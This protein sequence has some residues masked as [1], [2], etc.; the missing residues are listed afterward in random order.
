VASGRTFEWHSADG[1]VIKLQDYWSGYQVLEG[2]TGLGKP[3]YQ[4]DNEENANT[5]GVTPRGSR[6]VI[7]QVFLPMHIWGASRDQLLTRCDDLAE[8]IN[9]KNG[10]GYLYIFDGSRQYRLLCM[11]NSGMEGDESQSMAGQSGGEFWQK[12]GPTFNSIDPYF[13]DPLLLSQDWGYGGAVPFFPIPPIRLNPNQVLSDVSQPTRNNWVANPSAETNVSN[14]SNSAL[15]STPSIITRDVVV[16]KKGDWAFRLEASAAS[17]G[18]FSFPDYIG[19][20]LVVNQTYT[21]HGWVWVPSGQVF[22]VNPDIFFISSGSDILDRNQWSW[23]HLPFVAGSTSDRVDVTMRNCLAGEYLYADALAVTEGIITSPD[24][25]I[26][27]DQLYCHWSGTPH[28][29]SS[30]QDP[31]YKPSVVSNPGSAEAY[32]V[33]K[34]VGPGSILTLDNVRTGRKL[35]VNLATALGSGQV[36][37]IDSKNKTV[38]LNDGTNLYR[39]TNPDDFWPLMPGDNT[40]RAALSGASSGSQIILTYNPRYEAIV[41]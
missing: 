30:Y 40:I 1:R 3:Q 15:G 31:L 36:M 41:L 14:W 8:L 6:A 21:F 18:V 34:I 26:D 22:T 29:S 24:E 11:Y 9:P 17:T 19:T 39:Y 16:S 4:N 25:Y 38:K 7:R 5:D 27:G 2:V 23:F 32:P 28:G 13:E 12:T 33:W 35:A 20:P 37:T 10:P